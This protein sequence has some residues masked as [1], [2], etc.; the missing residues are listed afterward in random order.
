MRHNVATALRTD[1]E[2]KAEEDGGPVAWRWKHERDEVWTYGQQ[3][4]HLVPPRGKELIGYYVVQPLYAEPKVPE[5]T[6]EFVDDTAVILWKAMHLAGANDDKLIVKALHDMGY[7]IAKAT[8]NET[9][10]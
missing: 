7:V 8:R 5:W 9:V 6:L 1:A 4:K 3:P 10:E 2:R